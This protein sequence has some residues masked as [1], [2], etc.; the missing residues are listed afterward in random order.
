M[1]L[2]DRL[3]Q[4]RRTR[5]LTVVADAIDEGAGG[6]T[7]ARKSSGDPFAE[8]K[9]TVHTS[10]ISN[11]G[12][13]LYDPNLTESDLQSRVRT[14]LQDVIASDETP[15]PSAERAKLAQQIADDIL[16]YGPLEP[17]LRDPEVTEVMVN[18]H[19]TIYVEV[20]GRI[21]RVNATFTDEGHL[22]RTIDKIVGRVGRRVDESSPMVDA[23]LPDGSRVNAIVP[24]LAVDGSALTIRK[25]SAD[26]YVVDDLVAFGTMTPAVAGFLEACVRGKLNILV[27]GGTGAGKTTTLNVLSSFIPE[28]E[29]IVTIED[30]A[31]LQLHQEHVV[32]LEAR[33]ANIEGRGEVKIR[34]LV[35]NS[36]RMRP[37]RIV[38]GEVRDAA[39]LDM[40]QAMNTGHDGSICTVHANTP[41]DTLARVE[42][43]VLMG[44]A[45]LPIRAI[46][47][48]VSSA[49]DLVVQQA[50][51]KDGSRRI[52]HITE[53]VGMEGDII[54]LQDIFVYD[55]S[56]GFDPTGHALGHMTSTGLRPRFLSKLAENNVH[57]DT[58]LFAVER[59]SRG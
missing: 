36:L 18:G 15:L 53:V 54:T 20:S 35:K 30:A 26:P 19:D 33:P 14:V 59:R 38:V 49:I 12:S 48:Q 17:F 10:L 40:L 4:A 55:H 31:E 6:Q 22:R 34:D 41:R 58:A 3:A 21:A 42:T 11:L 45:D 29:R 51:F 39:A 37:D 28:D 43:M 24:P 25:F 50:R 27:A 5:E 46:R 47:E 16:G 56:A 52:T 7:R 8:I 13:S 1:S 57:V 2:S 32:R 23:R 9:A 44:G